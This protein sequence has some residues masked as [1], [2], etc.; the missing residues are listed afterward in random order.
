MVVINGYR[1]VKEALAVC[2]DD[3]V[4]RPSLP[5]FEAVL[6]NSGKLKLIFK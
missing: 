4:D 2:G 3:Y 1:L 6:G 5:L